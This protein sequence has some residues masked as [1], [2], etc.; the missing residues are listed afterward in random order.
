MNYE[1]SKPVAIDKIDRKGQS[2]TIHA[3]ETEREALAQRFGLESIE[4][5]SATIEIIPHSDRYHV[6]GSL[7]AKIDQISVASG[8]PFTQEINQDIDAWYADRSKIADFETAKKNRDGTDDQ[9]HEIKPEHDEPES[10]Y[11]GI[12]DLGEVAAQFLGLSLD[13]YPRGV[14]EPFGDYIEVSEEDAKP[15]PFAALE[16]LKEK[17]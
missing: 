12:I 1:F 10:I 3:N 4:S 15:N 8:E 11:D 2:Q 6:Q 13:N 14:D 16:K 7:S 17:K 9:D 5:L